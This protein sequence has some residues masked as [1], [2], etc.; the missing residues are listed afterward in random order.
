M[1]GTRDAGRGTG[2]TSCTAISPSRPVSGLL[3]YLPLELPFAYR[4]PRTAYR[5]F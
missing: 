3:R 4:V 1:I 5:V 2:K